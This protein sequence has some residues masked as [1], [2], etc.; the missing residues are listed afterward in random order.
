MGWL[1]RHVAFGDQI[2]NPASRLSQIRPNRRR[3]G[4]TV[5]VPA[6]TSEP[7]FSEWESR[8]NQP[9]RPATPPQAA[10]PLLE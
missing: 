6:N 9:E 2:E 3:G 1:L 4:G 8:M 10:S 5:M 7:E